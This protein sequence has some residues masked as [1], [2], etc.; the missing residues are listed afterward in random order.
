MKLINLVGKRFGKWTVLDRAPDQRKNR[1]WICKCDCGTIKTVGGRHLTKGVSLSCGCSFPKGNDAH[2]FKHGD[3][4]GRSRL[5]KIWCEMKARCLTP[6]NTSFKRYGERGIKICKE[7]ANDYLCF[8]AWAMENGYNEN[9]SIDRVNNDGDYTPDNCRW[10]T[11]KIQ[12]NNRRSTRIITH[13]GVTDSL[14]G[15]CERLQLNY[16]SVKTRLA[17]GWTFEEAITGIRGVR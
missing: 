14:L 6:G 7:W 9:L 15:H 16:N 17:R 5:Y 3:R 12:A 11:P 10:A 2:N 4:A 8:K 13:D 1:Y